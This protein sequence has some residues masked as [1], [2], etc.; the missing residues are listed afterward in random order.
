MGF[1][2]EIK[3]LAFIL[4]S[5]GIFVLALYD[6][7]TINSKE[8]PDVDAL[9]LG[10]EILLFVSATSTCVTLALIFKC[11]LDGTC[12]GKMRHIEAVEKL[13]QRKSVPVAET[14]TV[15]PAV[16]PEAP[17][18]ELQPADVAVHDPSLPPPY[19]E[20]ITYENNPDPGLDDNTPI[21]A[22]SPP[23]YTSNAG[24]VAQGVTHEMPQNHSVHGEGCWGAFLKTPEPSSLFLSICLAALISTFVWCYHP[25]ITGDIYSETCVNRRYT[26]AWAF[27][28]VI[29]TY[30]AEC[31]LCGFKEAIKRLEDSSSWTLLRNMDYVRSKRPEIKF[32]VEC[33]HMETRTKTVTRKI[34]GRTERRTETY[35]VKVVTHRATKEYK[36][37]WCRDLTSPEYLKWTDILLLRL[38]CTSTVVWADAQSAKHWHEFT[39]QMKAENNFDKHQHS[40]ANFST[41]VSEDVQLFEKYPGAR[42]WL[43]CYKY[44]WIASLGLQTLAFRYWFNGLTQ[45]R[46]IKIIKE[47]KT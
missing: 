19:E 15:A 13:L 39:E 30:L 33:Y 40:Y 22:G 5:I 36:Y 38:K 4:T 2:P 17:T 24:L 47:V 32:H 6:F 28:L 46:T 10:S 14:I 7:L 16:D 29:T 27:V 8:I 37:R 43:A 34:N 31:N 20:V 25:W 42:P 44:Y 18:S 21:V 35:E 12:G 45:S 1:C 11:F 41:G 26:L 3:V 23:A 9:A